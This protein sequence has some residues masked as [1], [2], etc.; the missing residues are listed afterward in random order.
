V[1]G[2]RDYVI[3]Y[4]ARPVHST[5]AD[6]L[7][8]ISKHTTIPSPKLLGIYEQAEKTYIFM[9]R[10]R[11][12]LLEEALKNMSPSE[13]QVI[14]SELRSMTDRLRALRVTDFERESYIGS[15]NRQPCRD[16]IFG[17][18]RNLSEGPFFSE[19]EMTENLIARILKFNYDPPIPQSEIEF[20]R[21]LYKEISGSQITFTHGDLVPHN[22]LVEDG[23]VTAI[24]DW[25]QSG[26][27]PAYWE[28]VKA[29]FGCADL[30]GTIWPL[31]ISR[32]LEPF[33]YALLVDGL[34]RRTLR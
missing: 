30:W 12:V 21:R 32:F 8:F 31:E 3:K 20:R 1:V 23:H 18:F 10:M 4:G 17:G 15:I 5:E 19:D 24:I 26:W 6:A 9:T 27:Y 14:S 33:N 34:I 22:I 11:G 13:L 16:L 28:F 29:M 2:V 25:G 7:E